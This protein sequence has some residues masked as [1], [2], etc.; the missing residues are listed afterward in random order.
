MVFDDGTTAR[1]G[2]NEYVM[3]TTTAN[4]VTVFRHLE[5]CRQCLWPDLDV[6]IISTTEAWAQFS[7]AGPNARKLLEKLVDQ[8]IS[9]AAFPYMGAGTRVQAVPADAVAQVGQR[10]GGGVCRGGQLA[11]HAMGACGR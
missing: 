11:P 1:L 3:T 2:P 4:A 5:F 9:D 6:Q 7:V 8:D 10:A